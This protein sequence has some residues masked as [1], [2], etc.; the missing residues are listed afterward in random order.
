[1]ECN[2]R[3]CP[4]SSSV[5]PITCEGVEFK[6]MDVSHNEVVRILGNGAY[7]QV[8]EISIESH[9]F[10]AKVMKRSSLKK[11]TKEVCLQRKAHMYGISPDVLAVWKCDNLKKYIVIMDIV[12][13]NPMGEILSSTDKFMEYFWTC[14]HYVFTLNLLA[15]VRHN[16]LHED[17]ILIDN[18]GRFVFIDYGI[19]TDY[20]LAELMKAVKDPTLVND[21][22]E[23]KIKY[24]DKNPNLQ[25]SKDV[26][27][28]VELFAIWA[29][30]N[31]VDS[32]AAKKFVRVVKRNELTEPRSVL[33]LYKGT[34][35]LHHRF[36]TP[37]QMVDTY[38]GLFES[39]P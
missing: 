30:H 13:G 5:V 12:H 25:Y 33:N 10:A 7:G 1:M 4:Y 20:P 19:S 9:T 6:M 27:E 17:N 29:K 34:Y 2:D 28:I 15:R 22:I 16:D 37:F 39:L 31:K 35:A 18:D 26:T 8:V 36:P 23:S 3:L 32:V 24:S 14:L 21:P 11:I 38:K